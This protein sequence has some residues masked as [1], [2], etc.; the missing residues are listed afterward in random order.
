MGPQLCDLWRRDRIPLFLYLLTFI[1]MTYPFVLR[2]GDSL[3]IHNSDT[4][5][6]LSKNWSLREALIHGKDLD[7]SELLFHPNGLDITL[8]P[9]RW[10]TFPLWTL[11]YTLFG[12][13]LTYNLVSLFGI[14]FKAYGMYLFGIYLFQARIPAWVCGA[15]Y[16][17]A[18]PILAMALRNPDT[19]AT[20]WIP[21]FMLSLIYG[22]DRLHAGYRLRTTGII[23]VIAGVCFSLNVYMHLRIAIFAVLLGGGYIVWSMFARRL[24]ARRRFWTAMLVFAL[25]AATTS[26][27]LL[28]RVLR[29]NLYDYA[30]DRP[31]ATGA[32]ASS[33]LLNFFKAQHDRPLNYRQVIASLSGDQLEIRCLCKGIS[34]V[35]LVGI[36]FA[37]MGAVYIFRFQRKEAIWIVLTA[38]SFLLSL[39]VVIYVNGKP[40][41]IYWTPYRLLQDNF[42]FRALWHPFRMVVVLLFPFSILVGYGLHSRVQSIQLDNRSKIMLVTSVI[43]LL[44]GTSIFPTAMRLSPR[45]AYLSALN[46]LPEGAV[47]DLPMGRHNAKYYMAMQRFHGRPMA[48]GMIPRTPPTAYDYFDANPVLSRLYKLSRGNTVDAIDEVE[49]RAALADLQNDGFRYLIL[50]REVPLETTRSYWLPDKIIVD[51]IFPSPVYQDENESIYDISLWEGPYSRFGIGGFT[52]LAESIDLNI[53]VGDEFRLGSWSLLSSHDVHPCQTV[54]VLSWWQVTHPDAKRFTLSVILADSDGDG[55]IAIANK[56][57]SDWQANVYNR[58]DSELHIPCETA[59]GKYPLLIVMNESDTQNALEFRYPD[60]KLI[61]DHYYLTTLTVH[62]P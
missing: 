18:A 30:I 23:M 36:V 51:I 50:H 3:P 8:Q 57:T 34:H 49:W 60:G 14:L 13:P 21:W 40:L 33:D 19:G 59:S 56:R 37:M 48:E 24:W 31:V 58:D 47:I 32:G 4:F 29:S 2:M 12:D 45:P 20:E 11:L 41:D 28:I 52:E 9:Q 54:K 27:P 22:L 6:I 15:F 1:V 61:G 25:T 46:N 39:G 26:A 43:M 53:S 17:F 7:H 42:F 5:E 10:T 35:G 16:A 55:Q 44:Y 62:K 38:L